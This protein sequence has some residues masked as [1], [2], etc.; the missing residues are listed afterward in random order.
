MTTNAVVV[1]VIVVIVVQ[2]HCSRGYYIR[3]PFDLGQIQHGAIWPFGR[4]Q[5]Q[6]LFVGTGFGPS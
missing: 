3:F 4:R 5:V 1:V 6:G 2:H